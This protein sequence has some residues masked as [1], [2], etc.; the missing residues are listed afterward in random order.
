VDTPPS[1]PAVH[2]D[3]AAYAALL[4]ID[5]G[6]PGA[7]NVVDPND[8]VSTEKAVVTLGALTSVWI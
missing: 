7:F 2:V 8:E 1:P 4:A 3:A 6:E 5:L